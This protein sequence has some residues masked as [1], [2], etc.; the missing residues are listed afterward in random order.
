[1]ARL[2]PPGPSGGVRSSVLRSR[3]APLVSS[4]RLELELGLGLGFRW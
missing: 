3:V 1:M 4:S 2:V